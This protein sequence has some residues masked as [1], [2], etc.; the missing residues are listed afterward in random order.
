MLVIHIFNKKR[1]EII[2]EL[3]CIFFASVPFKSLI[4]LRLCFSV[5]IAYIPSISKLLIHD[6]LIKIR[7]KTLKEGKMKMKITQMKKID[8]FFSFPIPF[9]IR[10]T[11]H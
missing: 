1:H 6:T 3:E 5:S 10:M 9:P 8:F 11:L 4:L 2:I 7:I